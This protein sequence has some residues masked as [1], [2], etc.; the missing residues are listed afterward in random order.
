MLIKALK[1]FVGEVNMV[2]DEVKE[3]EN[4][5]LAK[6]LIN[7]GMAEEAKA[8]KEEEKVKKL[9]GK[10]KEEPT[11]NEEPVVEIDEEETT[12]PVEEK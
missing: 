7:A 12:E 6:S 1:S 9:K 4:E 8:N 3:V 11:K 5:K 10:V 2:I